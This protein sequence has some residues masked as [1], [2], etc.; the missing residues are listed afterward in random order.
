MVGSI[1]VCLRCRLERNLQ[2][3]EAKYSD[4]Q[5]EYAK[6]RK[7]QRKAP[8]S[9]LH[10]DIAKLKVR[11]EGLLIVVVVVVVVVVVGILC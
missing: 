7:E 4:L 9:A 10:A 11:D 3:S 1:C 8:A 2:A 6:Y 5:E